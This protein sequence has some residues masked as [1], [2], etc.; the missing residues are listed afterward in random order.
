MR[1]SPKAK[2]AAAEKQSYICDT[3][4]GHSKAH[5]PP[6]P[7]SPVCVY[8]VTLLGNA[9]EGTAVDLVRG[10]GGDDAVGDRAQGGGPAAILQ[11]GTFDMAPPRRG[12]TPGSIKPLT[13]PARRPSG[14]RRDRAHAAEEPP[15][16]GRPPADLGSGPGSIVRSG[17]RRPEPG[18]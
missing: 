6:P 5:Q 1:T 8:P 17:D 3:F 18:L 13:W 2:D 10:G 4:T 7:G 12:A 16:R 11:Q 9:A 14:D 15:G